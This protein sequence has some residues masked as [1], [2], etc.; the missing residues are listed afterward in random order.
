MVYVMSL[1]FSGL[2]DRGEDGCR[3]EATLVDFPH[4]ARFVEMS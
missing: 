2:E 4:E 1:T 3:P